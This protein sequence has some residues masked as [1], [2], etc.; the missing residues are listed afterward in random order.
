MLTATSGKTHTNTHV[1]AAP[2][3]GHHDYS[4]KGRP[5]SAK[6]LHAEVI[7]LASPRICCLLDT[8]I[9]RC[10]TQSWWEDKTRTRTPQT[11][12]DSWFKHLICLQ[13]LKLNL[14]PHNCRLLVFYSFL[15][16]NFWQRAKDTKT[17][18]PVNV[19]QRCS[20]GNGNKNKR[21]CKCVSGHGKPGYAENLSGCTICCDTKN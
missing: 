5:S 19:P 15:P 10:K 16:P 2:T 17:R 7:S 21:V 18:P 11:H 9:S 3:P 12:L 20:S 4:K 14:R 8:P 6:D 1:A 13:H